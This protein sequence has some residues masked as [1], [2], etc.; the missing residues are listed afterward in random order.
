MILDRECPE[1]TY[2]PQP[3]EC[4]WARQPRPWLVAAN[5]GT[6]DLLDLR[7][8]K[9]VVGCLYD[10]PLFG[11]VVEPGTISVDGVAA[12]V[13]E[14]A[15]LCVGQGDEVH[16]GAMLACWDAYTLPLVSCASGQLRW[17]GA[18]DLKLEPEND[19]VTGLAW[20]RVSSGTTAKVVVMKGRL[21]LQRAAIRPGDRLLTI[22]PLEVVEGDLIARR[23]PLPLVTP[24]D[25]RHPEWVD[26][27]QNRVSNA[28]MWSDEDVASLVK[29]CGQE[30]TDAVL[31]R[32]P[33][34]VQALVLRLVEC[35]PS[36]P[37]WEETWGH[38]LR[39]S[40]SSSTRRLDVA[41][42]YLGEPGYK[43]IS[44][45]GLGDPRRLGAQHSSSTRFLRGVQAIKHG[46][47]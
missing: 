23:Q 6:V 30:T 25:T 22:P 18:E 14:G 46:R 36:E 37:Q 41:G 44:I 10:W 28:S 8:T 42:V 24:P 47:P 5:S 20:H 19:E 11:T 40:D 32:V 15:W 39:W 35:T 31:S 33:A 7:V 38:R 27:L 13:P 21:G 3:D 9:Y 34:A 29:C 1:L 2:F 4:D 43:R 26:V 17:C 16:A 45:E 12:S